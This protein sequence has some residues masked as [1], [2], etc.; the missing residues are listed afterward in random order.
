[1]NLKVSREEGAE[2]PERDSRL[3][4][5]GHMSGQCLDHTRG[6]GGKTRKW[7]ETTGHPDRPPATLSSSNAHRVVR[8][9]DDSP[10]LLLR[11]AL[12]VKSLL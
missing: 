6:A 1:M 3:V 2:G 4:A 7:A 10:E 5:E 9:F 8:Q 12:Q 11:C